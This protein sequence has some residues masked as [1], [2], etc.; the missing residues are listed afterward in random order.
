MN[1][2]T[3]QNLKKKQRNQ[4]YSN[5]VEMVF[6]NHIRLSIHAYV[7]LFSL[8]QL[9][10]RSSRPWRT[11]IALPMPR[12]P[13]TGPKFGIVLF[14]R[15]KVRATAALSA[16]SVSLLQHTQPC[17]SDLL[18]IP[19][20]WHNCVVEV[21]PPPSK[22]EHEPIFLVTKAMVV[23]MA[24]ERGDFV[25]RLEGSELRRC[26]SGR[27]CGDGMMDDESEDREQGSPCEESDGS[28]AQGTES[29]TTVEIGDGKALEAVDGGKRSGELMVVNHEEDVGV[30]RDDKKLPSK[31]S[32]RLRLKCW[33]I[34]E[35]RVFWRVKVLRRRQHGIR[36]AT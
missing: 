26:W 11:D 31:F 24:I 12:H 33:G 14:D 4:A 1:K 36:T 13:N 32:G 2:K 10:P 29:K 3:N 16:Q 28:L 18:H 9:L 15:N 19:T 25:G 35:F 34:G 21:S 8:L 6:P 17:S 20:P 27:V 5:L 22:K 23:R 7:L 30:E